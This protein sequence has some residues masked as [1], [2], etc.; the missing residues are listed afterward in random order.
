MERT[1]SL[2]IR[3]A[4]LQLNVARHHID[5]VDAIEQILFERVWDHREQS[6]FSMEKCGVSRNSTRFLRA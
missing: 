4:L 3:A 2:E 1:Q 6:Q 5:D